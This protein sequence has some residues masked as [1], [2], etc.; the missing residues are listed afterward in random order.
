[1]PSNGI[2]LNGSVPYFINTSR[3]QVVCEDELI[4]APTERKLAGAA[5][6]VRQVEPPERDQLSEM[7]NVIITPHISAFTREA[8]A[9]V[10][11]SVCQDVSAVLV[12]EAACNYVNFPAPSGSRK[13]C[14][15]KGA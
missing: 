6:D 13:V 5:L 1:M 10:V 2:T 15:L 4:R 14:Q 8:Q 9:R 7:P 3:G 11:Q 12:G